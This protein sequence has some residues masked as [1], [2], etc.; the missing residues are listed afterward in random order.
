MQ[1]HYYVKQKGEKDLRCKYYY[2]HTVLRELYILNS[3]QINLQKS[4]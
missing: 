4:L 1:V 3:Y 2:L